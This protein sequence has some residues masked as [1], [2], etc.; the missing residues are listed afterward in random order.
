MPFEEIP[1]VIKSDGNHRCTNCDEVDGN[2]R[3]TNC[4]EVCRLNSFMFYT[5]L[6]EDEIILFIMTQT[7]VMDKIGI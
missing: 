4:D 7:I 5:N 1:I 6:W 3:C 2:H